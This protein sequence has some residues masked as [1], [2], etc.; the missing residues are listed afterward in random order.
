M[1]CEIVREN[2]PTQSKELKEV[3]WRKGGEVPVDDK[4]TLW[5]GAKGPLA[6]HEAVTKG[7]MGPWRIS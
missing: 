5:D 6:N 2:G 3:A 4:D 1:S 7:T